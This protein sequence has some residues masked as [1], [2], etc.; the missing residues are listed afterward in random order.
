VWPRLGNRSGGLSEDVDVRFVNA[1]KVACSTGVAVVSFPPDLVTT[2]ALTLIKGQQLIAPD[3][4]GRLAKLAGNSST[5][6]MLL[7]CAIE[8]GSD[9]P[10]ANCSLQHV[11]PLATTI[12]LPS[13]AACP[14]CAT[15]AA[16]SE[17]LA[18]G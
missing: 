7:S 14:S 11:C 3:G 13:S 16:S 8:E 1:G 9:D 4:G 10:E 5:A 12:V 2:A 17:T 6:N 18:G 15:S